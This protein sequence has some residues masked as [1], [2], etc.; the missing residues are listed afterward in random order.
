MLNFSVQLFA[1][2]ERHALQSIQKGSWSKARSQLGKVARK[3]SQNIV[4][5]YARASYF[6]ASTNPDFQLDSANYYVQRALADFRRLTIK[7]RARLR[8]FP[9][10]SILLTTLSIQIDSIAFC[11]A[12]ESNKITDYQHFLESYPTARQRSTAVM[13]RDSSAFRETLVTNSQQSFRH[14]INTYPDAL[15]IPEAKRRYD[16]L[17]FDSLTRD[18]RMTSY[19]HYLKEHPNTTVIREAAR[20]IFEIQTASGTVESYLKFIRQGNI[21]FTRRALNILFYLLP[22][23]KL[24]HQLPEIFPGDSIKI[25]ISLLG[26]YVAPILHNDRFGFIDPLGGLVIAA[27]SQNIDE[28]YLCGNVVEEAIV[29]PDK[30][31]ARNGTVI[32]NHAVDLI[33]DIG[34][35]FLLISTKNCTRLVHK[36]GFEVGPYCID[37]AR[38]IN[39]KFLA[40]QVKGKWAV[41]T[42]AGRMLLPFE[43][44]DIRA[45][46]S[47]IVLKYD[48]KFRLATEEM[49]ASFAEITDGISSLMEGDELVEW[50]GKRLWIK[51]GQVQ[52]VL[53]L[54]LDTLV[55]V[56]HQNVFPAA[57]GIILDTPAGTQLINQTGEQSP[58]FMGIESNKFWT[59]VKRSEGW[60]LYDP[61]I[62]ALTSN[63]YDT[64]TF[65]GSV[66]IGSTTDSIY[67]HFSP[68][69]VIKIKRPARTLAVGMDSAF[70]LVVESGNKK[71]LY[72]ER[73]KR[74]FSVPYDRIQYI[75]EGYFSVY[76]KEK[77]GLVNS[78]GKIVVP[79]EMDAI[80]SIREGMASILKNKKFGSFNCTNRKFIAPQYANNLVPYNDKLVIVLTQGLYGLVTWENKLIVKAG[81]DEIRYWNDTAAFVRKEYQW[82]ICEI[83][84]GAILMDGIR[85]YKLIRDDARDKLAI[86]NAGHNFGV[87]HNQKGVV[88]PLSFTDIVNVG[89]ARQPL[90]FAE[91]RIEEAD[92]FVVLYYNAL[93]EMVR[94]EVYDQD[95]YE[96]IYCPNN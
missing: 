36:T 27:E 62:H 40:L 13:L 75:G 8:R 96:R 53:T 33:D 55:T 57:A 94:K 90:Y 73:G 52:R 71:D 87:I 19:Q 6:S 15:Q 56:E 24:S 23:D 68:A 7:Q 11:H 92:L 84:T 51:Q 63:P 64:V 25:A 30:V 70:Y 95:D 37:G 45:I 34:Y 43:L 46:G 5:S 74:L 28:E 1:Q 39:G 14:F 26:S 76:R 88:I 3:D 60:Y 4:S 83:K 20:N 50:S 67:V 48:E 31:V 38:V 89:S 58:V 10:D 47:V 86:I 69:A 17:L 81:F 93:G 41:Y 72:D 9:I 32:V 42:F 66:A 12:H 91:K 18:K 79:V 82:M 22:Q 65:N 77:I 59:S 49:L 29:L 61:L 2:V 78:T 85:H 54:A 80:G 35:G 21:Y 16:Q 44:N